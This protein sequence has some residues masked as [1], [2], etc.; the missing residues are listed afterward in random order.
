MSCLTVTARNKG[1]VPQTCTSSI[2]QDSTS[3]ISLQKKKLNSDPPFYDGQPFALASLYW[4]HGC[5]RRAL[6]LPIFDGNLSIV[7]SI[8]RTLNNLPIYTDNP[9][10]IVSIGLLAALDKF[11][12]YQYKMVNLVS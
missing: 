6:V 3:N 7:S 8:G 2:A 5:I 9:T 4:A 12:L 11:R 10:I 1:Y